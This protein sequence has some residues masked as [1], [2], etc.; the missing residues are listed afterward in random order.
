[1]AITLLF[2]P[3]TLCLCIIY[4]HHTHLTSPLKHIPGPWHTKHTSLV[5]TTYYLLGQRMHYVHSLHTIHGPIVRVSPLEI[6]IADLAAVKEIHR[7][8]TPFLKDSAFYKKITRPDIENLFNTSDPHF[9]AKRRRLFARQASDIELHKPEIE[10]LIDAR[11]KLA[12]TK[13]ASELKQTGK[14]DIFQWFIF[15]TTDIIG[16]LCFGDSFRMIELGVG[17]QYFKDLTAVARMEG[18]KVVFPALVSLASW[19]PLSLP[20]VSEA[21]RAG[22]RLG[23]YAVE[24]V[25]R[26]KALLKASRKTFIIA[27]SDTTANTLTYLIYTLSQPHNAPFLS[28][29]LTELATLPPLFTDANLNSLTTLNN[30][31]TETMRLYPGVPSALPRVS[32]ETQ[33]L[34]GYE[35]PRNTTVSGQAYTLHRNPTIFPSPEEFNPDRWVNPSREMRDSLMAFGGGVRICLGMHLAKMEMRLAVARFYAAFGDALKVDEGM[36]DNEMDQVGWFLG[37]PKGKRCL[38]RRED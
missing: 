29:L 3:L 32:S 5:L 35:I 31:I 17:N 19:V 6:S 38:L 33:V 24:S 27:G 13:I 34:A 20:V 7:I 14:V 12:I 25:A 15:M 16:E 18:V 21:A 23:G 26:Y 28:T 9:H 36:K 11:I 30:I 4:L 37:A 2:L 10:T 1:M 22:E 8:G